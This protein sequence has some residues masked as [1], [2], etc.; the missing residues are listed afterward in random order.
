MKLNCQTWFWSW[1]HENCNFKTT[2]HRPCNR[3]FVDLDPE[4][5]QDSL[6]D[7]VIL[8]LGQILLPLVSA[9]ST[10]I[11][12][13]CNRLFWSFSICTEDDAISGSRSRK[14]LTVR[15]GQTIYLGWAHVA[16]V[17]LLRQLT[18]CFSTKE[19]CNFYVTHLLHVY[20]L[21]TWL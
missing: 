8:K 2:Y 18:W 13:T 14:H 1:S 10:H 12:V 20:E 6:L 16:P 3:T 21:Q 15:E 19:F 5:W 9:K 4:L 17:S 11:R 7:R